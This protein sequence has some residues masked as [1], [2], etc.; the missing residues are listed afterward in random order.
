M[1]Q[2]RKITNFQLTIAQKNDISI[3]IA[4]AITMLTVQTQSPTPLPSCQHIIGKST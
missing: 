2:D 3:A 4:I 1:S